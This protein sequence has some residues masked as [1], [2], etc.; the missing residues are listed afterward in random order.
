M[1]PAFNVKPFVVLMGVNSAFTVL[2]FALLPPP[3][4]LAK[5][6]TATI[7]STKLVIIFF[8]DDVKVGP[9]VNIMTNVLKSFLKY[10]PF[11]NKYYGYLNLIKISLKNLGIP[12]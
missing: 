5:A 11:S 8:A 3:P 2:S 12:V 4:M 6:N 10:L 9:D 1:G 7:T